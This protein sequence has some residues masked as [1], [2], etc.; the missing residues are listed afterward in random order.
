MYFA[1]SLL[2]ILAE[3]INILILKY[4]ILS[5]LDID[6][7]INFFSNFELNENEFLFIFIGIFIFSNV[8]QYTRDV[9]NKF[10]SN[11]TGLKILNEYYESILK[12]NEYNFSEI[13]QV[14]NTYYEINRF[15][16]LYIFQ[17]LFFLS[18][19]TYSLTL[20][21]VILFLLQEIYFYIILCIFILILILKISVKKFTF[22]RDKQ[23]KVNLSILLTIFQD[24]LRNFLEIRL[25]NLEN[26]Y[27]K[28]ISSNTSSFIFSRTIIEAL[29]LSSK[30]IIDILFIIVLFII[31]RTVELNDNDLFSKGALIIFLLYRLVPNISSII[32][33]YMT[34]K[35]N[36][37]VYQQIQH[38]INFSR[39][40]K[41]NLKNKDMFID[42]PKKINIQIR[43]FSFGKND[44]LFKNF[45]TELNFNETTHLVGP[46]GSGK[47]TLL[48]IL[49]GFLMGKNITL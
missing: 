48:L 49:C 25:F 10:Y 16:Q 39:I 14:N 44:L 40:S 33:S 36:H 7:K 41:I 18:K 17:I 47:S 22:Q 12:N 46:N 32:Y 6:K 19:F 29:I 21:I 24:L 30:Y 1:L 15:N 23:F 42:L 34:Y 28:I 2:S 27:L 45:S 5:I 37:S 43:K 35:S 11:L 13:N 20:T 9:F 38:Y 31:S 3:L 8:I 4:F 26:T